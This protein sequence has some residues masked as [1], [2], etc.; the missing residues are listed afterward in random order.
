MRLV[1][2]AGPPASWWRRRPRREK[3]PD[4]RHR[5]QKKLRLEAANYP[6]ARLEASEILGMDQGLC[7]D[8]PSSTQRLENTNKHGLRFRALLT[9][10]GTERLELAKA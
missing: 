7:Q 8:E 6:D 4:E 5:N 9:E 2:G 1:Y 10:G 3:T